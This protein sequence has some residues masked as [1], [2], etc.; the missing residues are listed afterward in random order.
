MML[1][2]A[3]KSETAVS[4]AATFLLGAWGWGFLVAL[5][6]IILGMIVGAA[7]AGNI[8]NGAKAEGGLDKQP[9]N[10]DD[11]KTAQK[12][13]L[14]AKEKAG[15][16]VEELESAKTSAIVTASISGGVAAAA[17][18][19]AAAVGWFL[20]VSIPLAVVAAAALA[21]MTAAL[22]VLAE[23]NKLLAELERYQKH[24][25]DLLS[26]VAQSIQ[27]LCP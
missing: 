27:T 24:L 8:R 21:T 6:A 4:A 26:L 15:K 16:I 12:A 14:E 5:V 2:F 18:I 25:D 1:F 7:I 10:C 9:R 13:L 3:D 22:V 19:A 20:P 11:A 17:A 23:V